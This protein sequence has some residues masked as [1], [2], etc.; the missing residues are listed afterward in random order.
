MFIVGRRDA[1]GLGEIQAPDDSNPLCDLL[2]NA[3]HFSIARLHCPLF[4][5]A[6]LM[7]ENSYIK[8][9]S[10][11]RPL[12]PANDRLTDECAL[13]ADAVATCAEV[14]TATVYVYNSMFIKL[15]CGLS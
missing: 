9:L 10:D 12:C 2:V 15:S 4:R 3:C 8:A 6:I 1:L 7:S 14:L 13:P 11:K 5:P